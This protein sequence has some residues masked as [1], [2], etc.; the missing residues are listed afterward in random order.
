M[1]SVVSPK[2]KHQRTGYRQRDG[3][4]ENDERVAEAFELSRQYQIDENRREQEGAEKFAAFAPKLARLAR[5]IDREALRQD[6]PC[7]LFQVR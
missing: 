1:F 4:D 2:R 3:A 6:G 5:V 7:L